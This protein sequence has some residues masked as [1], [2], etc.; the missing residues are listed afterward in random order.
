MIKILLGIWYILHVTFAQ[1]VRVGVVGN[2]PF[3]FY[4]NGVPRGF[5][6]EVWNYVRCTLL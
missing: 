1:E 6:I 2:P 5:S 3:V 4:V